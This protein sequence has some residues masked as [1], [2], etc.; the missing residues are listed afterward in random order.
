MSECLNFTLYSDNRFPSTWWRN[1]VQNLTRMCQEFAGG[2]YSIEI[3]HMAEDQQRA[4]HDGVLTT[5][6]IMLE[7][8]GGRKQ[9]LGN[10]VETKEFLKLRN[11][12]VVIPVRSTET[13]VREV[14]G[15][16][17]RVAG[18]CQSAVQVVLQAAK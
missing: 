16:F 3:V 9:N 12:P 17:A 7:M 15:F 13:V 2:H 14:P 5:P 1:D 18:A 4:F 10:F 11:S 8:E 6:T